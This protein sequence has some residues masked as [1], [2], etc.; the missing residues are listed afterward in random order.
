MVKPEVEAGR[1]VELLGDWAQNF[2][3]YHLYYPHRRRPTSA[4]ALFVGR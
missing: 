2:E 3:A 4:F 1:L